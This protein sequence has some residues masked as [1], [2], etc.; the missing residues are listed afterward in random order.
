MAPSGMV[1]SAGAGRVISATHTRAMTAPVVVEAVP[2]TG[3]GAPAIPATWTVG[4]AM[5]SLLAMSTRTWV[6]GP[7][8]RSLA[9]SREDIITCAV[10]AMVSSTMTALLAIIGGTESPRPTLP[11][12]AETSEDTLAAMIPSGVCS[13]EAARMPTHTAAVSPCTTEAAGTVTPPM[14]ISGL[15]ML[16][17]A[18]RVK[19]TESALPASEGAAALE[20]ERTRETIAGAAV[21]M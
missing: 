19:E 20:E 11:E 2:P 5:Y 18:S 8:R 9:G 13:A 17:E 10:G 12:A 14:I 6:P 21:Q 7:A 3:V 15:A 16:S 1:P 4:A